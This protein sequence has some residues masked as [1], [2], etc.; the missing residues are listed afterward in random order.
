MDIGSMPQ[1]NP[2]P[3]AYTNPV[4]TIAP[5]GPTAA[6]QPAPTPVQTTPPPPPQTNQ[7]AINRTNGTD[8]VQISQQAMNAVT[9][10]NTAAPT[11]AMMAPQTLPTA[12]TRP[13]NPGSSAL[14]RPG[15]APG[16]GNQINVM[17]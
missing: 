13:L 11:T 9:P 6:P 15:N 10:K 4:G 17:A 12:P 2:I 3:P 8:L 5:V 16:R 1:V 14:G 7:V